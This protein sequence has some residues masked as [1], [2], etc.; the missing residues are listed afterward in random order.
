VFQLRHELLFNWFSGGKR[1]REGSWRVNDE[2][3]GN[4]ANKIKKRDP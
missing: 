3:K 1:K 2:M 4:R